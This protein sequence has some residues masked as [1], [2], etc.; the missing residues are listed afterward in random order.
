MKANQSGENR[1]A[2]MR[3]AFLNLKLVKAILQSETMPQELLTENPV[4]ILQQFEG[5]QAE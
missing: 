2:E 3:L 5:S 4:K 1:R